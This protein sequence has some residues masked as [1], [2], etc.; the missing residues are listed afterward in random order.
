MTRYH[1]N[2]VDGRFHSGADS[3]DFESY[4]EA[5]LAAVS[6]LGQMLRDHPTSP[7]GDDDLRVEVTDD[8]GL[9]LLSVIVAAIE[10]PSA[11]R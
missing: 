11:P 10:A 3:H 6:T 2:F 4:A 7:F 9:I 1:F 5:R 8:N